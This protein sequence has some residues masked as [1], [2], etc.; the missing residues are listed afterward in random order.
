MLPLYKL[1]SSTKTFANWGIRIELGVSTSFVRA[2]DVK[3]TSMHFQKMRL[4][5]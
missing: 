5:G 1:L 3:E 4:V 2:L